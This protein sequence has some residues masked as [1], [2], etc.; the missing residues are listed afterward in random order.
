MGDDSEDGPSE[1]EK[2]LELQKEFRAEIRLL[3]R[4]SSRQILAGLTAI[5]AIVG[6][7]LY[8]EILTPI[9]SVPLVLGLI[10]IQEV[11]ILNRIIRVA[12]QMIS[13]ELTGR[14]TL[15]LRSVTRYS[16]GR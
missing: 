6:Y 5:G 15:I 4:Q 9:S 12:R 13:I 14:I 16:V 10:F 7:S 1:D 8:A 11:R 3:K 2:L